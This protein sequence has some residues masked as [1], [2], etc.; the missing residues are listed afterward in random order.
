VTVRLSPP[1]LVLL[2]A[3]TSCA[4][5]PRMEDPGVRIVPARL[6]AFPSLG[7]TFMLNVAKDPTVDTDHTID[8]RKN[9]DD[10]INYRVA[11]HGGRSF[12]ARTV[13]QLE[14]ATE[15]S[16]WSRR[17]LYQVIHER[18]EEKGPHHRSVTDW[19]FPESLESWRTSLSADFVLISQFYDGTDTLGRAALAT[20]AGAPTA[21]RRAIACVV[22][23][24]DGRVVWC[25]YVE[26]FY[27]D[28]SSR[29]GAQELVDKLLGKMLAGAS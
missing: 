23:L 12:L 3:L 26:R 6:A 14:H 8:T 2:A 27:S 29:A 13:A 4:P 10:A 1:L 19:S 17:T 5:L 20:F 15:F 28:L 7:L 22:R 11:S 25:R 24:E 9:V 16:H 21:A 18:I